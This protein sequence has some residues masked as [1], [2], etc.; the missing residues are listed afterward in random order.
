M[1]TALAVESDHMDGSIHERKGLLCAVAA[2]LW[3]GAIPLYFKAV[4]SVPS[5]LVLDHRIL[6]SAGLLII[7]VTWQRRWPAIVSISRQKRKLG[8]LCIAAVLIAL[9]WGT[10]IYAVA[11]AKVM[12][13]SLGYFINP[14]ISI[15]L[16]MIFLRER[17][18]PMQWVA[19]MIA[20]VGVG[21]LT[22]CTGEFPWIA[23]LC[24]GSFGLYGLVR[25]VAGV[26]PID[27]LAVETLVLVLPAGCVLP[28]L[29]GNAPAISPWMY[30]VLS[31]AG[32]VTVLPLFWFTYAVQHLRLTTVGFLQYIVP[33]GQFL[34]ALLIFGEALDRHKLIAFIFCWCAVVVYSWSTWRIASQAKSALVAAE[35]PANSMIRE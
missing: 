32:I 34:V 6:W 8:L 14:L 18:R 4:A 15:V 30:F 5:L 21:Y 29:T 27:G 35:T 25:R 11:V 3:W 16:G 22:W 23:M 1:S 9:N 13:A 19:V 31:L 28:S 20:C 12:Q 10:F 17:L 26:E 24:A 2:F 33:T 7:L